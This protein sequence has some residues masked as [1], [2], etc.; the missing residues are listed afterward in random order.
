MVQELLSVGSARSLFGER[1]TPS[2]VLSLLEQSDH[3]HYAGHARTAAGNSGLVLAGKQAL[4]TWELLGIQSVPKQVVLSACTAGAS[5]VHS[6]GAG[7]GVAQL[8][9]ARGASFVLAPVQNI[10]DAWALAVQRRIYGR[11]ADGMPLNRAFWQTETEL[12]DASG[13]RSSGLRLFVR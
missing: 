11:L 8:M 10:N 1:A 3:L 6:I 5:E 7:W 4:A 13:G 9:L 12:L 2:A